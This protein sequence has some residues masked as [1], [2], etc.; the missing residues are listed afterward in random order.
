MYACTVFFFQATIGKV[1]SSR[2]GM[3]DFVGRAKWDAWNK[4]GD[5]TTVC[6]I[7]CISKICVFMCSMALLLANFK[8][9][10]RNSCD[11]LF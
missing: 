10:S 7:L 9:R 4:L 5:I 6:I 11:F 1:N 8:F 3:M 2:P